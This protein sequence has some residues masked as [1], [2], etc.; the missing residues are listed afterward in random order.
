M[1]DHHEYYADGGDR[2][3]YGDDRDYPGDIY[4]DDRHYPRV[5]E[6]RCQCGRLLAASEGP[7]CGRCADAR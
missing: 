3:P 7:D 2:E 6:D 1:S 5:Y 4:S